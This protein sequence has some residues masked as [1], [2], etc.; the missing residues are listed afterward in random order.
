ML[1]NTY[2]FGQDAEWVTANFT[3]ATEILAVGYP[4]WV[5]AQ[6]GEGLV[7]ATPYAQS[8][9]VTA[10]DIPSWR[11][12]SMSVTAWRWNVL[13]FGKMVYR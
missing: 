5:D 13:L 8:T 12:V 11:R 10:V 9:L 2:R 3:N 4:Q 7:A 6:V 1:G